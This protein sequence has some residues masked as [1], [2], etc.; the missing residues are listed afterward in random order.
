MGCELGILRWEFVTGDNKER[1]SRPSLISQASVD[2]I[3]RSLYIPASPEYLAIF[4]ALDVFDHSARTATALCDDITTTQTRSISR[5]FGLNISLGELQ[6][7]LWPPFSSKHPAGR[8][9][10]VWVVLSDVHRP[11]T[12]HFG[13]LSLFGSRVGKV[14]RLDI[15]E[16]SILLTE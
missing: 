6:V 4:L 2:T 8:T 11:V 7:S 9:Y 5:L 14:G 12:R 1:D 3:R 15:V 13:P 10:V 16:D